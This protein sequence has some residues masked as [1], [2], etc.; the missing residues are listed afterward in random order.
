M[1]GP[2]GML[3]HIREVM[4][5]C[6][7]C[8]MCLPECPTYD[9]TND[10][11]SSPR[12]RIRLLRSVMDGTLDPGGD[13]AG[14]MNFCLDCRACETAC[15]AG[16]RYGELV[17]HARTII[18]ERKLEPVGIRI[19]KYIV[20]R[21]V[22]GSKKRFGFF[23]RIARFYRRSGLREAVERSG[24]LGLFPAAFGRL[25]MSVPDVADR[26]FSP[27]GAVPPAAGGSAGK[28]GLLT[29]CIMNA[30]F[31][32][33][34]EDTVRLLERCGE[35]V[36]IPA[37]QFCCGSLH[38]HNGDP[39]RARRLA[40]ALMKLFPDDL[41]AVIVNSAGCGS[42]MKHY[43][44]LFRDD[45]SMVGYAGRFAEK[46]TDVTE[47]IARRNPRPADPRGDARVTYHDACHLLHGQGVSAQPR[48][49]LRSVPG[50]RFVELPEST[51]C[52][53]SAGIYN[54]LRPAD[55][56]ELLRRKIGNILSTG[57]EIVAT[58]NPGCHLQIERGLR[59]AGSGITVCHPVTLLSRGV[60]AGGGR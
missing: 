43:G 48:T 15:P 29:G 32:G 34:H 21:L 12:G 36:V 58:A 18:T 57:A 47:F 35:G 10:E 53:G 49:L 56:D 22:F 38:G 27:D 13:F 20:L 31:P 55:S 2:P 50:A 3:S 19:K 1:T 5:T 24:L 23:T 60:G 4:G 37:G 25:V 44:E 40:A 46:V 6:L 7:H 52:C 14:E 41:D 16:V 54:I 51:R 30:A 33:V 39:V 17:E 59:A 42:F 45:P 11:R 8:G 28:V 26:D 9:I